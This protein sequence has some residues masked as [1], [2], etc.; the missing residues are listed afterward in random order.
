MGASAGT[1]GGASVLP[2]AI[3]ADDFN[4]TVLDKQKW[5]AWHSQ[6]VIQQ[7]GR[8]EV[9]PGTY[10]HSG[11]TSVKE[12]DLRSCAVTVQ[13][14]QLPLLDHG[15]MGIRYHSGAQD[16]LTYEWQDGSLIATSDLAKQEMAFP[17]EGNWL[18]ISSFEGK[19]RFEYSKDGTVWIMH[20][21]VSTP[22]AAALASVQLVVGADQVVSSPSTG[23]FDNFNTP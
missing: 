20:S 15:V 6:Y 11:V 13:L 4:G 22:V 16:L 18:R 12:A 1:G 21:E 10:L 9:S 14:A 5:Y 17:G 19:T 8:L 3:P 23:A 7:G 2:C